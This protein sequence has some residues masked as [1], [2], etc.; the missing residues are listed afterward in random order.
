MKST[1][2]LLL[3]APALALTAFTYVNKHT[4]PDGPRTSFFDKTGMDTTVSPGEN[5]YMYANGNWVKRTQIPASE[6]RWGSFNILA[7]NDVKRLHSIL[8][9]VSSKTHPT[10]TNEQKV[11]DLYKS[12]MDTVTIEKLGYEPI[13]PQL[14]KIAAVKNY[15]ELVQLAADGFKTGDGFLFGFYVSPDDRNSTM[16]VAH[17]DQ[18]GLS[19]PNRDYYF[20]TDSA[21]V[22]I[23]AD[24]V[25][26]IA[27]LFVLTG[28]DPA[29]AAKKADA[30][31]KL[32]TAVAQASL[33]P[34]DL[35][36][37][38]RNYNKF[39]FAGLE[40][41]MPDINLADAFMRMSIKADTVLVGQPGYY[42]ALD[43]ILKNTPIAAWKDE[44]MFNEI[45]GASSLLSKAFRDANFDFY[46]KEL[47]GQKQPKERWKTMSSMI[48]GSLGDL[49]GQIYVEKYFSPEA[50]KRMLDLVNNLQ[51]VYRERIQ[52]VDWM[53]DATKVKALAKLDAFTKKI[54][55]PDKW[56]TYA[57][58][59]I[60]RGTYYANEVSIAKH[61]YRRMINKLGKPVD[62]TE[63]GMT[64]PTVNAYY[65]P[66]F[67]EI[68]FPAGILQFPFFDENADDAINYG[69]IGMVIGHEMT[70]G[71]D[72][73]GRQYD[74]DGN[75]SDWWTPEDA[76]KFKAKVKVMIDQ[77]D[78]FTV[79]DGSM[80]V[81][82]KL[83]QG[84]NLAD[85]GGLAIAYEAFKRTPEG[86][87]N[88]KI[89]GFTPDQRFFLSVAQIWRSR[90]TDAAQRYRINN[91]P[92]SPAQFRVNGPLSNIPAFY[93]AFNIKPGDKMYRPDSLRVK[94]W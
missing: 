1:R 17:F 28:V 49:L 41:Q 92:H 31:M 80:H 71:F 38:V 12:G 13:K 56:K 67:N 21:S 46:S 8:E 30:V 39:S 64:P 35:R 18:T 62:K 79:L 32:E 53:S 65:N 9:D 75:L 4:P 70:H 93:Q 44:A 89:D 11:G 37:P 34:T 72:D 48:D 88:V 86:K 81:N 90:I 58:V 54:A 50:K 26:Y 84:E 29:Y 6:T 63:W 68:V 36:D 7:D 33:A 57:D 45:S 51:A 52:R 59:T 69:G 42:K 74:K 73:Q 78:G 76:T 85:N 82:G 43:S 27:K 61:D 94:V 15:R 2:W 60:N 40:K 23:R 3:A 20:K 22:A 16:N 14:A 25:K 66:L 10:G 5:F 47:N 83:T 91:D 24:F 77:Y 87:S 19:L 55:Y